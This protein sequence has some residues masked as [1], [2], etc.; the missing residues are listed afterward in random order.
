M[1]GRYSLTTPLEGVREVFGF[2]EQPNLAPRYNIAPTQEVAAVRLGSEGHQRHFVWLK[3]GLIPSWAKEAAIGS[4]MI[5]ARSETLAE[6]PAF[7]KAFRQ[8]RCLILADSFYEWKTVGKGPKQP[9]RISL[10]GEGVFAFAGLWEHWRNPVDGTPVESCTIVTTAA[11][12]TLKP[13]HHRMPVI[14]A[15]AAYEAWL[16]GETALEDLQTLLRPYPGEAM[17]YHPISTRVNKVANDDA[18]IILPVEAPS[19]SDV[20]VAR[21]VAKDDR[22]GQLF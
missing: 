21:K 17:T 3:W 5:N 2:L 15:P 13:I 18:E 16:D 11:N 4:R 19:E 7:R 9:Y 8:R 6:K 12:D 20:P 1:C 10:L 14:L 22:Q